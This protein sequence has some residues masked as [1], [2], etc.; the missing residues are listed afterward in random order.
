MKLII[1]S[2]SGEG[3]IILLREIIYHLYL[4]AG[5][6][7]RDIREC[8]SGIVVQA[9]DRDINAGVEEFHDVYL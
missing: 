5:I 2:P 4:S 6:L 8:I 3:I 9:I 1:P 7:Q